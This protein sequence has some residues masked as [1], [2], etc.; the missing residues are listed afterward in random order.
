MKIIKLT[1]GS[2]LLTV[3]KAQ[4]F[5]LIRNCHISASVNVLQGLK[6][7][8]TM[9]FTYQVFIEK[10]LQILKY[11]TLRSKSKSNISAFPK[12]LF[13]FVFLE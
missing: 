10:R 7:D 4:N 8:T 6:A 2:P 12:T 3:S 1:K 11:I 13:V 9:F 5:Q